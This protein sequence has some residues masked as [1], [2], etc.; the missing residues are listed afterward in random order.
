MSLS[1]PV[2][3]VTKWI[4]PTHKNY[5]VF[6][7]LGADWGDEGKGKVMPYYICGQG[8]KARFTIRFNGGPNAGHTIYVNPDHPELFITKDKHNEYGTKTIK[9]ATHQ[10]PSGAIFGVQSIIGKNCVVDL[11]KLYDEIVTVAG[12]LGRTYDEIAN[13]ITI[14]PEAHIIMPWH[15]KED[16]ENN[17]VGTT[18]TGIGPAYCAKAR[19]DGFRVEQ[20]YLQFSEERCKELTDAIKA[21]PATSFT[22]NKIIGITIKSCNDLV[23]QLEDGD[24]IVM[25]GAQG[26]YLDPNQ[27]DYPYVTSSDCTVAGCMTYGF[28][29]NNIFPVCCSKAC[30]TYVGALQMEEGFEQDVRPSG[31]GELLRLLGKEYGVTTG[32]RRQCLVFNLDR[33]IYALQTNQCSTWIL[34]K[35]DILDSYALILQKLQDY[36]DTERFSFTESKTEEQQ[37]LEDYVLETHNNT[38]LFKRLIAE[39]AYRLTFKGNGIKFQSGEEMRG[40]ISAVLKLEAKKGFL[41]KLHEI[42]WWDTP[43]SEISPIINLVQ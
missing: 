32:R 34:S 12:Q 37:I 11:V 24:V 40:Y 21:L 4:T 42:M 26:F 39:G 5:K 31:M 13:L 30:P 43:S 1:K 16:Q 15:V 8:K 35:S 19:R 17:K 28:D 14:T 7:V 38:E 41:P 2:I 10:V 3:S 6:V 25:E 33:V 36:L 9:F 20:Y 23:K 29:W 27:G 18:G 22:N